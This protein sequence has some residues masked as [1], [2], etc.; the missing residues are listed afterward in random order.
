VIA[1]FGKAVCDAY[2]SGQLTPTQF[3]VTEVKPP[4]TY[5]WTVDGQTTNVP[6]TNE[7]VVRLTSGGT[8][9]DRTIHLARVDGAWRWFT[10]CTP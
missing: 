1:H 2:T 3:S 9:E 5:A 6:D 7:V 10:D 4:S 8:T